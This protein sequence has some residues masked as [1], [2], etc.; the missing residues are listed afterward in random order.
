MRGVVEGLQENVDGGAKLSRSKEKISDSCAGVFF[1][2]DESAVTGDWKLTRLCN[3]Y[4][5]YLKLGKKK[6]KKKDFC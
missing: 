4:V 5:F 6:E 1:R 3:F 2:V